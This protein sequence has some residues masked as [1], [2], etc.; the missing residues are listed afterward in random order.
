ML[1]YLMD[2]Q[3]AVSIIGRLLML[4]S[5]VFITRQVMR[6]D[7][8]FS[9]LA[10][11]AV[12]T[13]LFFAALAFAFSIMFAGINYGWLISNVSGVSAPRGI[14]IKVYCA[15]NLY[16][17]IPGTVLYLVGRNRIAFE[18]DKVTHSQ[19]AIATVAEGIFLILAAV[20]IIFSFVS[21]EAYSH[22]RQVDIPVFAGIVIAAVTGTAVLLLIIFRR[23]LLPWVKKFTKSLGSFTL[24]A[25][26]KRLCA[27][28]VVIMG[29]A[30][31]FLAVLL[32]LG[33]PVALNRIPA[34]LGIYLLS[35]MI[36]FLT[37]GAGSGMGIREAAL[38]MFL[39][40]YLNP[41]IVLQAA[42]T[43]RLVCISGDVMAYGITR[44][45]T[46]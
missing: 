37:P 30:V 9:V 15:S 5:L 19:I 12:V 8:D 11:P 34:V 38:L 31:T 21:E 40:A 13:G 42:I 1:Q 33:Q 18:T 28:V 7:V 24:T 4:A 46:L 32:L 43:H 45:T 3:K 6:H 23:S 44:I 17:Y 39:G 35:W 27:A 20:L 26:L 22:L 10:S 29:L 36:G 41:A 14:V 16:K 2:K 25:K